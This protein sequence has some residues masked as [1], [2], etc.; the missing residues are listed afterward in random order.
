MKRLREVHIY[1]GWW[2]VFTGYLTQ[3]WTGGASGWVFGVLILPMQAEL[4]WSR[5]TIVGVLTLSRL[6]DGFWGARLGPLVDKHGARLL[7]T[8]SSLIGGACLIAIS[9]VQAPW[10]S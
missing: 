3:M 8:A 7:M 4:G 1:R 2:I 5:S 9:Q 6:I 10:Q